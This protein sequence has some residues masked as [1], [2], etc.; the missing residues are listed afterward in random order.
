MN[1]GDKLRKL[2]EDLNF[3]TEVVDCLE[4][5]LT[6]KRLKL[7]EQDA[8]VKELRDELGRHEEDVYFVKEQKLAGVAEWQTELMEANQ[9]VQKILEEFESLRNDLLKIKIGLVDH[10]SVM[11]SIVIYIH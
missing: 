7:A 9:R 3:K 11:N 2:N 10:L 1:E 4:K 5:E 6:E 8:L